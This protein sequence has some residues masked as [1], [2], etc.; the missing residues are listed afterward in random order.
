[1]A[2]EAEVPGLA[3]LV[4]SRFS[5]PG[6]GELASMWGCKLGHLKLG[7]SSCSG[8]PAWGEKGKDGHVVDV[9]NLN[10]PWS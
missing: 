2:P 6:R 7:H 4:P 9:N 3:V 10:C 8:A 1:M 5:P